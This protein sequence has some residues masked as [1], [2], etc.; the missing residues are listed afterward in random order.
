MEGLVPLVGELL[1][2]ERPPLEVVDGGVR[3]SV[4]IGEAFGIEYEGKTGL[5]TSKFSWAA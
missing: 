3:H 2:V 4:R 5:S 1:G